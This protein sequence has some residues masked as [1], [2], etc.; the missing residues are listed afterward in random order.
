MPPS[1]SRVITRRRLTGLA[2]AGLAAGPTPTSLVVPT[3]P[4]PLSPRQSAHFRVT[5]VVSTMAKRVVGLW[6]ALPSLLPSPPRVVAVAAAAAAT[7]TAVTPTALVVT[8]NSAP[9]RSSHPP[10]CPLFA[11]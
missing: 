3:H 8:N 6:S 11:R 7:T 2:A 1:G 5:E 4:A 10:E 9:Q